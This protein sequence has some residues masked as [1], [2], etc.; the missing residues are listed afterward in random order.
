MRIVAENAL[1]LFIDYQERLV[2]VM[3]QPERLMKHTM[4]LKKGIDLLGIPSIFTQQYTKGLGMTIQ[5]LQDGEDQKFE[6]L[7]KITFSVYEDALARTIIDNKNVQHII[8]CGIEAHICVLQTVID[9]VAKG[10]HVIVIEDCIDARVHN[11]KQYALKRMKQ[12][13][14]VIST[15][16]AILF[17]LLR[18]ADHEKFRLISAL[19]K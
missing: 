18:R 13:G 10:Y 7:E 8:I 11:D 12:E 1:V 5:E 6:Y 19:I 2:P 3:S 17:E 9:L 4:I 15:Y 16:E 14:A